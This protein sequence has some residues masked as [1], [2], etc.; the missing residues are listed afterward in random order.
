[1]GTLGVLVGVLAVFVG[2][3]GVGFALVVLPMIVMMGRHVVVMRSRLVMGRRTVMMVARR[4]LFF[5][6][7]CGLPEE[8][9]HRPRSKMP[10]RVPIAARV[11][12]TRPGK[13][14]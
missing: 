9:P 3:G 2:L 6:L 7:H 8:L 5:F 13:Q 11:I 4:V 14:R 12:P 1:M 10:A